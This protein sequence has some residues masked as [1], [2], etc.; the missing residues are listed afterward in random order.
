[1]TRP[2]IGITTFME[3]ARFTVY[4]TVTAVIPWTYIEQVRSAGGR[5]ILVPPVPDGGTEVLD[6]IDGLIIAGGAD[7]EPE[8]YGETRHPTVVTTP[9]RDAGE[10]PLARYA[11]NNGIPLLGICRGLQVMAVASG[12]R[13]HQHLPDVLGSDR[14]RSTEPGR[15]YRS[16]LVRFAPGS[17][18]R[19]LLGSEVEVN[20]YHH[21][22]VVDPG[23]LVPTGWCPDDDL[24]EAAEHP[25]HPFAVGVQ[26]HPEDMANPALFVAL[27]T[28]AASQSRAR[29]ASLVTV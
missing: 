21:Q 28:A 3:Q 10:L 12:G 15:I 8:R 23:R 27:V 1:M 11:L 2:I 19:E 14:H 6:A 29:R 5:P 7:V 16:H 18:C 17:K 22:G 9:A 24:I 20:S 26:W 25:D 4:D 13:L